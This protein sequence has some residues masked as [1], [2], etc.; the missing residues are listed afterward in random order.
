MNYCYLKNLLYKF[1]IILLITSAVNVNAQDVARYPLI[2][3]PTKLTGAKG[4][5]IITPK[6][7]IV[8]ANQFT[9]EADML[10]Q[11]LSDGIGTKLTIG[12]TIKPR[13]I[14]LIYD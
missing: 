12:K 14:K 4:S 13:S 6:T 9:N 11:L 10:S 8:T 7:R 2:P 5:F 3:Y 1:V